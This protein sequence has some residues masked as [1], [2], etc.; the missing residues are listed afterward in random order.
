MRNFKLVDLVIQLHDIATEVH[1]ETGDYKLS[2]DIHI[3]ADQLHELSI[4][5]GKNSVVAKNIIN[6]AKE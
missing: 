1:T 3:C 2:E 4:Q 5:D 6:K